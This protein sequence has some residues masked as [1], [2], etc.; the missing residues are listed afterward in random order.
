[1]AA[2]SCRL[3]WPCSGLIENLPVFL[4]QLPSGA[5]R[6][7]LRPVTQLQG[8]ISHAALA[9]LY[10]TC[11]W[12]DRPLLS[13]A[14]PSVRHCNEAHAHLC[15]A[16]LSPFTSL[17]AAAF[18]SGAWHALFCVCHYGSLLSVKERLAWRLKICGKSLGRQQSCLCETSSLSSLGRI[19]WVFLFTLL[20]T[21]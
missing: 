12:A 15:C 1:M 13:T 9:A 2:V 20:T 11:L 7:S 17:S 5:A 21:G 19:N 4:L 6:L 18:C 16:L 14:E 8:C 10:G 3:N